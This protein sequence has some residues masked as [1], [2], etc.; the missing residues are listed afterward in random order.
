MD[1][2][3]EVRLIAYKLWEEEACVNG[4]DWKHWFRA[5][6]IWEEQQKP[7]A[8]L[9]STQTNPKPPTKKATKAKVDRKM[10]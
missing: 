7:K 5:E 9:K 10:S 6:A 4:Q 8:A 1:R 2:E 3:D